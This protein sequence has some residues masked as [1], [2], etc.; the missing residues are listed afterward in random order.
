[1]ANITRRGFVGAAAAVA[2]LV[3]Q[4]PVVP[5]PA[6]EFAFNMVGGKQTMLSSLKGKTTLVAFLIST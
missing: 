3:A 4:A 2:P 1:M 6:G 5:R